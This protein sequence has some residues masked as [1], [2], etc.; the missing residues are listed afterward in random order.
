M[1][2]SMKKSI[3]LL[4]ALL[5]LVSTFA[6]GSFTASAASAP[7]DVES[8]KVAVWADPENVLNQAK[9]EAFSLTGTAQ[10]TLAVLGSVQPFKR[11]SSSGSS[12]GG[13]GSVGGSSSDSGNYYWFFP[14]NA[15][16]TSLKI[17]F[18]ETDTLT[19][20]STSIT[21]GVATDVFKELNEGGVSKT[22]TVKLNNTSYTVTAMKSG[23]VGTVYI[24]TKSGSLKTITS[25]SDHSAWEAGTIM[26]VQPDGTVDY[27]GVMSKMSGRGNGTWDTSGKK[28]PYNVKLEKSTSLLGMGKAKKWCLLANDVDKSLVKNQL[29]Y[30]F[31]DYIGIKY[32]PHCK[33]V[34][35]Y[36]N[37]QYLGSY[38]LSEKVEIKS[39]RVNISDAYENLEIANGTV[40]SATGA[41]VPADFAAAKT[42]V[43]TVNKTTIGSITKRDVTGHTVGAYKYSKIDDSAIDTTGGYLYELEISN[44]WVNENAGFCAYNRQGWVLKSADYASENM[45]KYSYNLLYALGASV[46]NSGVVPSTT[47]T[48]SCPKTATKYSTTLYG[49]NSITNPAPA[50][51][52]Q[53]KKWSDLLDADSA[54]RYY[55]TQEFFK[56]MDSSTS[57]TYFYKDSDS[58]DSKLYAGPMWDMDNSM[59]TIDSKDTER[60]GY[61]YDTSTGWYTKNARIYRWRCDDSTMSYSTDDQSPLNF[62]A[63]LATNCTDFWQMAEKYYYAYISPAADILLGKAEDTTGKLHSIAYY[64]NTINKSAQ[65]DAL[66]HDTTYSAEGYIDKLSTWT[67]ERQTWINGQIKPVDFKDLG[68]FVDTIPAQ[69]Y[70]GKALTPAVT[71]NIYENGADVALIPN[72]DYTLSYSNNIDAGTASVTINGAGLYTGSVTKTFRINPADLGTNHTAEIEALS[73]IDTELNPILTNN[74]T[75]TGYS[76]G[77]SYQWYRNGEPIA[78]AVNEK[79]LTTSEDVGAKLTCVITGDG[80]NITGSVTSNECEVLTGEKPTG[81]SRTIASWNYNYTADNTLLVNGDTSGNGFYYVATGGENQATSNL[82]ASVNATDQ[83][84]LKWSGTADLFTNNAIADQ[85]PVMGT[86]K[87]DMLAWGTYPYFETVVSTAGYENIK[88]SAKLG[89]T[90]KGPRDWKLQYSLDGVNYTDVDGTV[91][92]IKANKSMELAFDNVMLP[93]ECK[94]QKEVHI[95][96]VVAND[97]AINNVNTIVNQLSGDAAVNDIAVTG[98]SLSV[99]TALYEPT[100]VAE[101]GETVFSDSS[102]EIVDNNG[103]ADLYY[104]VNGSEPV[105][106]T[107]KI[108]PFNAKTS[109]V[110][111]TAEITAY[112]SFNDIKS[113]ETTVTVTFG[114]VDINSFVYTDYSTNVTSGAVQSTGGTYG[115][116]GKMTAYTDGVSQYVPLWRDDHSSFCVAPDD[117]AKWSENSGFTYKVS[118]AGYENVNFSCMAYTTAQGPK[119]ITLQYSL[120]GKEFTNIQSDIPLTANGALEQLLLTAELPAA[121]DNQ[122]VLYLRLATTE[123]LS[124]S[125]NLLHNVDAKGNLYV[126]NVIVAGDDNGSFKMPYTNKST[127]YFGA[128]GTV[129]Y[130]SPDNLPMQYIV[131]D[132]K[133]QIVLSGAYAETGIQLSSAKYFDKTAQEAYT[134]LI[135]AVD[136]EE[137]SVPNTATY[138]Y[139]GDSVVKFNYNDKLNL[140]ANYVSSDSLSVKNTSGANSGTLS[141]YPNGEIATELSYTEKYGVRVSK[142]LFNSF[143]ASKDLDN[144][145][146]NGFWLIETSTLGY[147]NLTLNLEQL[148]SNQGPRDWGIA[149]ST[150]GKNYTYVENSNARAISNDAASSTVETYGNLPLPSECDNQEKLYVKVFINGGES[151]DRT[152]LELTTKGNTGINSIE[153]SGTPAARAVNFNIVLPKASN[154]ELPLTAVSNADIYVDG[155]LA[156][157]ADENGNVSVRLVLGAPSKID[158]KYQNAV[159]TVNITADENTTSQELALQIFDA[160][161]DGYVN[162]KDFAIIKNDSKYDSYRSYFQN[163]I[164]QTAEEAYK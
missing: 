17:W 2:K 40:D 32:Q 82:Y 149:Y 83:A 113:A 120:D 48:T 72:V 101:I 14:S 71:V 114:G 115:E 6:I 25:S 12:L 142:T 38:Q 135:E 103:G 110:G 4:L 93:D 81:Y 140:F 39:N 141:M 21:S 124:F 126:N 33:P 151:V 106:Y 76:S 134:V 146:G 128:T 59:G 61:S 100:I 24:D 27:M 67:S 20:D 29:T 161:N 137:T 44:R 64:V 122:S 136:D 154:G 47:T 80:T 43:E 50:A 70:T 147:S 160:N 112:A 158:I 84:K 16:L 3:A 159:R 23:D 42:A 97:V 138:Y 56:N 150:D 116:S 22:Y 148:S 77:V 11:S 162:A 123:N 87:T 104:S 37:Q 51:E 57:S 69:T 127:N 18:K 74:T 99:V 157:T 119:S 35:L 46:Y 85:A 73:Y 118:T 41:I 153:I 49:T 109:K 30:D 75:G 88:F 94:N 1:K 52:Y 98:T 19:I 131:T 15:D 65:M 31:A 26:V 28:N 111:D 91:Y 95:R 9:V 58:V 164:N 129:K 96:M 34:D 68:L 78:D 62:Y 89:G 132:S 8:A 144:P 125:G 155:R 53:G 130:I 7:V 54:V 55:W 10:D 66:R 86:S 139:K 152:E 13:W 45:V 105:L 143:A 92:S 79:Y 60:W 107:G 5:M 121:C 90:K 133:G 156:G 102:I 163:Y 63:A 36:V 145:E 108:N 117:G